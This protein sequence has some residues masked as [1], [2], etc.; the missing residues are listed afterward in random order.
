MIYL[1]PNVCLF[2]KNFIVKFTYS[3][4]VHV[5]LSIDSKLNIQDQEYLFENKDVVYVIYSIYL[6]I[7]FDISLRSQ[8]VLYKIIQLLKYYMY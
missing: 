3:F 2:Q 5:I 7:F 6:G 1:F 4:G 8:S